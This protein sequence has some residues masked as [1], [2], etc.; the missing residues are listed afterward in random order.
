MTLNIISV[1]EVLFKGEVT[2][3]TLPGA[4]GEFT[5]LENHAAIISTLV[6][7]KLSYKSAGELK[8]LTID[9]GIV[10][11]DKNIVSVCLY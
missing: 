11:V 1:E 3:V 2:Q 6:A 7:G 9:G 10:D 4:D 5:V 8:M